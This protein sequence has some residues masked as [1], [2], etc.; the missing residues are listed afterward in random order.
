[1]PLGVG[2]TNPQ[3]ASKLKLSNRTSTQKSQKINRSTTLTPVGRL[4]KLSTTAATKIVDAPRFAAHAG[5][6]ALVGAVVLTGST[7]HS[8]RLNP[9]A[10]QVGY[11]S[12]IDH[13]AEAEV[14]ATVATQT[15]LLVTPEVNTN[16]KE[17]GS[18]ISLPTAGDATLANQQVVDTS[19]NVARGIISY[20]VQSGDTLSTVAAKFNITTDTVRWANG[21]G[22]DEVKPNQDLIILPVS[23]VKHT[24]TAGETAQSLADK[25][26]ANAEQ[27]IAFNNA[28]VGGLQPGRLVVVPDG[29]IEE[30]ARPT[31]VAAAATTQTTQSESPAPSKVSFA[32]GSRNNSY[33]YGYCTWYVASKRA[34]PGGWGNAASWYANARAAGLGVGS[35]PRA[36]AIAWTGAGYYGHVALVES[37]NGNMVTVSE[38]N[39]RGW[40]KVSSRTVPASSFRYIY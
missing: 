35:T 17:L 18:Q 30:T 13:A 6:L 12:V 37:V 16:A 2:V 8:A 26:K 7:G 24:I 15:N 1:M 38:M 21:I 4:V 27:I 32:P 34:V 11:G 28:E 3:S 14:A 40:N 5:I 22:N 29:V 23:G 10:N 31:A 9:L 19:G 20:K 25:Y 36:G 39:Y 33:S